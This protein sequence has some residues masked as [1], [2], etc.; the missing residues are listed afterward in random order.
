M[1]LH[2]KHTIVY[3]KIILLISSHLVKWKFVKIRFNKFPPIRSLSIGKLLCESACRKNIIFKSRTCFCIAKWRMLISWHLMQYVGIRLFFSSHKHYCIAKLFCFS[4]DES[5]YPFISFSL[6]FF[7]YQI[8]C[9]KSFHQK[10][11]KKLSQKA[12]SLKRVKQTTSIWY[13]V[14]Q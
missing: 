12:C 4:V 5:F 10:N 7:P 6:Q 8:H 2:M 14:S 11:S 1:I 9:Y 3:L 13:K